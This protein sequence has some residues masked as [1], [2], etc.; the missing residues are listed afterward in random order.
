MS[1]LLPSAATDRFTGTLI[2]PDDEGHGAARR[3]PRHSA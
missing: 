3:V 1:H 2:G